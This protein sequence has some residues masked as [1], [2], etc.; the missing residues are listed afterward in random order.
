MKKRNSIYIFICFFWGALVLF[1]CQTKK[2]KNIIPEST[3]EDLLYDY[4]IAK[5]LG[6]G[7][8]YNE[9][10]KRTLYVEDV[11]RKYGTTE[12]DFDSSMVWYTRNTQVLSTIYEKINTRFKKE[13]DDVKRLIA[14]RDNKPIM[15]ESGDSID[16]WFLEKMYRITGRP[17]NNRISFNLPSDTNFY[18]RDTL[19]W[20]IN[21]NFLGQE[22][23]IDSAR[24]AIMAMHIIYDNDSI[25]STIKKILRSGMDT[26]RL[27]SD[28]LGRIK[29]IKGF[30]YYNSS[31]DFVKPLWIDS[32]SLMRYHS[33]D[34]LFTNKPDT[35][36]TVD[37]PQE[38]PIS[39]QP[40]N[41]LP[42]VVPEPIQDDAPRRPERPRPAQ[43]K[44]V[45]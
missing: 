27:Q 2:P 12:A 16:V 30:V 23:E 19:L 7:L 34:T 42:E 43:L 37:E 6:D 28:T 26:I 36:A 20:Q 32:I 25:I 10:Y 39:A 8:P 17:L 35:V 5:A 38:N 24:A 44:T 1:G 40:E 45:D 41:E 14:I 21:Y 9:N 3:M 29:E 31:D 4:H 13:V 11:F 18:N 15:S 22:Q 33:N